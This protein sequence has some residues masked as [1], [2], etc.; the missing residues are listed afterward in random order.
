MMEQSISHADKDKSKLHNTPPKFA[1][2]PEMIAVQGGSFQMGANKHY[3]DQP[4]HT[5]TVPD[6]SIGK[7][8]VT[9]AQ[10]QAVM[11]DNPS[12]S[13]GDDL[14]VE[15]VSWND[16]QVFLEK[17]NQK[18]GKAYR[19]PSEAEWEFAARGGI[20]SQG[21]TYSGSNN[22]DDVAWHHSLSSNLIK[23]VNDVNL[24]DT[25]ALIRALIGTHAVGTKNANELGIYDMSGNV[26]EWCEDIWHTSYDGAPSDGSAW[27]IE[28]FSS[29]RVMRGGSW[30][31]DYLICSST[32]RDRYP[33][34]TRKEKIGFRLAMH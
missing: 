31:N 12:Y 33:P 34:T 14:P 7:Y 4:I 32:V 11:G 25:L 13:K 9:Q 27:I 20:K 21:Y 2:E 1:F 10:W 23:I 15:L 19:R 18:T 22:A 30:Y 28:D 3:F 29:S 17:I 6:F 26:W 5:V 8:P 24:D 16:V